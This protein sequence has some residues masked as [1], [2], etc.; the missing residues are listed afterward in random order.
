MQRLFIY[1]LWVVLCFSPLQAAPDLANITKKLD[2]YIPK[3]MAAWGTPGCAVVI[4][5]GNDI[6]Y[7]KAFGS[8]RSGANDPVDD[9]TIFFLASVSKNLLAM[10]VAQL[11]EEGKLK[12]DDPVSKYLPEF[13]LSDREAT[14]KLTLQDLL[15]HRVGL[16]HF[17]GDS[18]GYLQWTGEEI[19]KGLKYIPFKAAYGEEYG[20]QN[21]FYG[22][23]GLIV[24]KVS[25]QDLPT[26]YQTRIFTPLQMIDASIGPIQ[27]EE[28]F[29]QKIKRWFGKGS[30]VRIEKNLTGLH[31][32]FYPRTQ[33]RYFPSNP[34]LYALPATSGVNASIHDMGQWLRFWLQGRQVGDK[35]LL[36]E[37]GYKHLTQPHVEVPVK[38]KEKR[39]FQFP[40]NRVTRNS[41]G[42]GWFN[43]DYLKA[44]AL[45]QMGGMNG[46]RSL[47]SILP[48]E[49]IGIIILSNLG[50]MRVAFLPESIRNAFFD[51]YLGAKEEIDWATEDV[52]TMELIQKQHRDV[53]IEMRLREPT[54]RATSLSTYE[55]TYE[56]ELYGRVMIRQENGQLYLH[57]RNL[58]P[59]VLRHWNGH[60]FNFN[61]S[62]MSPCFPALD[63]G[64]IL[65]GVEGTEAYAL[66]GSVFHEGRT[67]LFQRVADE[68]RK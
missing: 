68:T 47:L 19:F 6:V 54:P 15:S 16:P 32:H 48:E 58:S 14:Q 11:V 63:E 37:A 4:V 65:F 44:S 13:E 59:V 26:L 22:L 20:Y 50:G 30:S 64:E 38:K 25:G 62:K 3:A 31:D 66:M 17:S 49:N 18:L 24:Q 42:V 45:T 41:Y 46:C 52:A 29:W 61:A 9:H 39:D 23:V 2:A 34:Y 56:H 21:I 7:Q 5:K 51:L 27:A 33:A 55:G 8:K 10:I 57:Y 60:F 1:L 67:R 53:K 35:T 12:W 28:P 43:H 36:K 40:E